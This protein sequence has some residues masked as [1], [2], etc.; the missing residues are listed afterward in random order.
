MLFGDVCGNLVCQREGRQKLSVQPFRF[1]LPFV[2]NSGKD[3]G[4]F[5]CPCLFNNDIFDARHGP[6]SVIRTQ[7]IYIYMYIYVYIFNSS[8][9]PLY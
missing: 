7:K 6:S 8:K 1:S 4:N 3:S 9:K 2:K 5:V